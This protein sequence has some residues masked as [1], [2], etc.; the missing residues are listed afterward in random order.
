MSDY[1]PN[2]DVSPIYDLGN[3]WIDFSDQLWEQVSGMDSAMHGMRWT[4]D[5][6]MVV[7][8]TWTDLNNLELQPAI[9]SAVAIGNHINAYGDYIVQLMAQEEA[10]SNAQGLAGL[11]SSILSLPLM[12]FPGLGGAI[13]EAL[14]AALSK[15]LPDIFVDI[16]SSVGSTIGEALP[17]AVK[18]TGNVVVDVIGQAG[19][20]LGIDLGSQAI[21]DAVYHVPTDFSSPD[22]WKNEAT[23]LALAGGLPLLMH[24]PEVAGPV[25]TKLGDHTFGNTAEPTPNVGVHTEGGGPA[26]HG[27]AGVETVTPVLGGEPGGY[28]PNGGFTGRPD[29]TL[30]TEHPT[31][32]VD[33]PIDGVNRPVSMPPENVPERPAPVTDAPTS[34]ETV[35]GPG[36][37]GPPEGVTERPAPVIEPTAGGVNRP[38]GP[39]EGV[40]ERPAPV[41]EPVG[42]GSGPAEVVT[43]PSATS[44]GP[45][46]NGSPLAET[47]APP[48]RT[49]ADE[50]TGSG[51]HSPAVGE[52]GE[53]GLRGTTSDAPAT[54]TPVPAR[55]D[56]GPQPGT[57]AEG[58]R[59]A[60]A[61][62][63]ER[64]AVQPS[65]DGEA[66]AGT[67]PDA[68]PQTQTAVSGAGDAGTGRT[69][70][71]APDAPKAVEEPATSAAPGNDGVRP[72]GNEKLATSADA[73]PTRDGGAAAAEPAAGAGTG[74]GAGAGAGER[75]PLSSRSE[76]PVPVRPDAEA[77]PPT[78]Q[79][80][81]DL[82]KAP[83]EDPHTTTH[84]D[85]GARGTGSAGDA[86]RPGE[87]DGAPGER[88]ATAEPAHAQPAPDPTHA[89][90]T[91]E[92]TAP[93][94][95]APDEHFSEPDQQKA[96]HDKTTQLQS[97][98]HQKLALEEKYNAARDRFRQKFDRNVSHS[99]RLQKLDPTAREEVYAKAE[100]DL[101]AAFE[102][103]T[104][105]LGGE[106]TRPSDWRKADNAFR[107]SAKQLGGT[108]PGRG[109][110][111]L[112]K[113]G[114][115]AQS[116]KLVVKA[117]VGW[118][119]AGLSDGAIEQAASAYRSELDHAFH[120]TH[121]PL[122]SK[123]FHLVGAKTHLDLTL[124]NLAYGVRGLGDFHATAH[125]LLSDTK[126]LFD[127]TL[128]RWRTAHPEWKPQ[129]LDA[130]HNDQLKNL[131]DAFHQALNDELGKLRDA[132]HSDP[133]AEAKAQL[134]ALSAVR[135][136]WGDIENE[137]MKG[138]HGKLDSTQQLH[139]FEPQTAHDLHNAQLDSIRGGELPSAQTHGAAAAA[140]AK[141]AGALLDKLSGEPQ[142]LGAGPSLP[143]RLKQHL[144]D[145][146]STLPDRYRFED[147]AGPKTGSTL[148]SASNWRAPDGSRP[149]PE[150]LDLV[151]HQVAVKLHTVLTDLRAELN[152]A[153]YGKGAVDGAL[154]K[155]DS[156]L[157]G[158]ESSLPSLFSAA[159]HLPKVSE[160]SHAAWR[161]MTDEHPGLSKQ[162]PVGDLEAKFHQDWAAAYDQVATGGKLDAGGWAA[163]R[164][165]GPQPTPDAATQHLIDVGRQNLMSHTENVISLAE[166]RNWD[167]ETLPDKVDAA[168][169]KWEGDGGSSLVHDELGPDDVASVLSEVDSALKQDFHSLLD[170]RDLHGLS[171]DEAGAL[172]Q[173]WADK[174]AHRL[175]ELPA[176]FDRKVELSELKDSS[177]TQVD[178]HPSARGADPE[179]VKVVKDRYTTDQLTK[180][181]DRPLGEPADP[182]A[183]PAASLPGRFDYAA[184]VQQHADHVLDH[185]KSLRDNRPGPDAR[186]GGAL[187][188]HAVDGY[189]ADVLKKLGDAHQSGSGFHDYLSEEQPKAELALDAATAD[190]QAHFS[191]TFDVLPKANAALDHEGANHGYSDEVV[192]KAKESLNSD[193]RSAIRDHLAD[194]SYQLTPTPENLRGPGRPGDLLKPDALEDR[195]RFHQEL[196]DS[197]HSMT[198]TLYR[199]HGLT[200]DDEGLGRVGDE[201]AAKITALA[202]QHL[203]DLRT[204]ERPLVN[205]KL[206][207]RYQA[208]RK[209]VSDLLKGADRRVAHESDLE[210]ALW[211]A[212]KAF[213]K[214]FGGPATYG[215]DAGDPAGSGFAQEIA[216]FKH[217]WIELHDK[218]AGD[219]SLNVD[220]WLGSEQTSVDAF[221]KAAGA[222]GRP[223]PRDPGAPS[224]VP[225][226]SPSHPEHLTQPAPEPTP[227]SPVESPV[228]PVQPA[229]PE[230]LTSELPP[231]EHL[232]TAEQAGTAAQVRADLAHEKIT[233]EQHL[234]TV[235]PDFADDFHQLLD[236]PR[237]NGKLT[238]SQLDSIRSTFESDAERAFART[239]NSPVSQRDPQAV[240][241]RW[242]TEYLQLKNLAQGR[243]EYTIAHDAAIAQAVA[244]AEAAIDSPAHEQLPAPVRDAAK[245]SF[246][247]G[248]AAGFAHLHAAP[249]AYEVSKMNVNWPYLYQD[250]VKNIDTHI[251][252]QS[253]LHSHAQAVDQRFHQVLADH[254]LTPQ[255][256]HSDPWLTAQHHEFRAAALQSNP[257][258]R[259]LTLDDLAT[260]LGH[261][262]TLAHTVADALPQL[263]DAL[264]TAIDH[265]QATHGPDQQLSQPQIDD[266]STELASE[267]RKLADRQPLR[268]DGVG[269][270]GGVG[271]QRTPLLAPEQVGATITE[272]TDSLPG[273]ILFSA[274]LAH[275]AS[276]AIAAGLNTELPQLTGLLGQL[277]AANYAPEAVESALT[278]VERHLADLLSA[279]PEELAAEAGRQQA[280]VDAQQELDDLLSEH[281]E[282][283]AA[284]AARVRDWYG[285]SAMADH[286]R[287]FGRGD[288][289]V[290]D[291][292][293]RQPDDLSEL[294]DT[295]GQSAE[296]P[297][298]LPAFPSGTVELGAIISSVLDTVPSSSAI[299][300]LFD[301]ELSFTG[302]DA[303]KPEFVHLAPVGPGRTQF[304]GDDIRSFAQT[305]WD[306]DRPLYT[307]VVHGNGVAVTVSTTG[308]DGAQQTSELAGPEFG[309]VLARRPSLGALGGDAQI[310][311]AAC[312]AGATVDER[313]AIG[314]SVADRSGHVVWAATTD[315]LVTDNLAQAG[316]GLLPDEQG[317]PGAW[318]M[319]L[320]TPG[321][322]TARPE[323][324]TASTDTEPQT[325]A[326]ALPPVTSASTGTSAAAGA[327]AGAAEVSFSGAVM[328]APT[329]KRVADIASR[330][331]NTFAQ[332]LDIRGTGYQALTVAGDGDCFFT[333]L[334]TGAHHQLGDWGHQDLD[335]PGLRDTASAWFTG[336]QGAAYRAGIDRTGRSNLDI[337][338]GDVRTDELWQIT[339]RTG[340]APSDRDQ[341]LLRQQLSDEV[342]TAL[343]D[344]ATLASG[345]AAAISAAS[346]RSRQTWNR[347]LLVR[348]VYTLPLQLTP[349]SPATQLLNPAL[350]SAMPQSAMVDVAIRNSA[351]WTTQFFDEV[352]Q[353]TAR[354]VGLN[355]VVLD[356]RTNQLV[357]YDPQ[358]GLP[359]VHLYRTDAG[360]IGGAHYSALQPTGP[361]PIVATQPA[362]VQPTITQLAVVSTTATTTATKAPEKAPTKAPEKAKSSPEVLVPQGP[363]ELMD[364]AVVSDPVAVRNQLA[365][366]GSGALAPTDPLYH[367]LSDPAGVLADF[368]HD[369]QPQQLLALRPLLI[370]HL[371][372]W[373]EHHDPTPLAGLRPDALAIAGPAPTAAELADAV[374][375]WATL[376]TPDERAF[377]AEVLG[378]GLGLTLEVYGGS[379]K[380]ALLGTAGPANGRPVKAFLRDDPNGHPTLHL[381]GIPGLYAPPTRLTVDGQLS[382]SDRVL[383]IVGPQDF[384]VV[385][386][387]NSLT[388]VLTPDQLADARAQLETELSLAALQPLLSGMTRGDNLKL[389]LDVGG[390]QGDIEIS[391]TV[392]TATTVDTFKKLEFEDGSDSFDATGAFREG[393]S[394]FGGG[395]ILKGKPASETT[396]TGQLG[397]QRDKITGRVVASSGRMF[398]RAKTPEPALRVNAGIRLDFDFSEVRR[399]GL[400]LP[401]GAQVAATG[402]P[403]AQL[404]VVLPVQVA[405][406]AAEAD[407]APRPKG[408][409][410][411]LPPLRIEQTLGLGGSDVV[412]DVYTVDANGRRTKGGVRSLLGNAHQSSSLE[413]FGARTF[414]ADWRDVKDEFLGKVS[415]LSLHTSLKGMM[416]GEPMEVA[417]SESRG[418][419]L[420]SAQVATLAHL[421]N[422]DSSE[423]NTGTDVTRT[424]TSSDTYSW[425]GQT[426]FS[427][428]QTGIDEAPLRLNGSATAQY[429]RDRQS[430]D[431]FS[432][433][434]GNAVKMKVPG[435]IFNGVARLTFS[436]RKDPATA[437]DPALATTATS[438]PT[439]PAPAVA[440]A[441]LGFQVL[442]E[443]A[444][445]RPVSAPQTFDA[446]TRTPAPLQIEPPVVA[447]QSTAWRPKAEIW[448]L[449]PLGL[450]GLPESAVVYDVF[451]GP[452]PVPAQQPTASLNA[453]LNNLGGE[454]FGTNDWSEQRPAVRYSFSRDRVA[455]LLP[456]M[457]RN[458]PAQ[459]PLLTRPRK[460]DAQVSATAQLSSFAFLRVIDKAE[461]NVLNEAVE[462]TA[463]RMISWRTVGGQGQVGYQDTI[464]EVT[465]LGIPMI[466]GGYANRHREG[467]RSG[468]GSSTVSSAKFPEPM[469]AYLAT[470]RVDVQVSEAGSA[471]GAVT[472][473]TDVRFVVALP[474]SSA[475]QYVVADG[476][477]GQQIFTR[478]GAEAAA[479]LAA[480]TPVVATAP[481]PLAYQPPERVSAHGQIGAS[482]AVTKLHDDRAVLD[483]LH[484]ALGPSFADHWGRVEHDLLPYFDSVALRPLVPALTADKR[485]GTTVSA[486]GVTAEITIV[487]ATATMTEYLKSIK[488]FEFEVGSESSA[489]SGDMTDDLGTVTGTVG[490][491][492]KAPHISATASHSRNTDNL[493]SSTLDSAANAVSK[494]KTVEPAALFKGR[495]AFTVEVKLSNPLGIPTGT[496]TLTADSGGEFAFPI[497]DLPIDPATQQKPVPTQYYSPPPGIV[498]SLVLNA[499]TVVLNVT[500]AAQTPAPQAPAVQQPPVPQPVGSIP[501]VPLAPPAS[502][503]SPGTTGTSASATVPLLR[504]PGDQYATTAVLDQLDATGT[505][506][507]GSP[508]AWNATKSKLAKKF[509]AGRLQP[510]L[511]SLM[512]GQPWVIA[513]K[514]GSVTVTASVQEM[515]HTGN[516]K[517]SEFNSGATS[518]VTSGGSDGL[519][520]AA[521]G[522]S[523]TTAVQVVGASDPLGVLPAAVVAGGT[524]T[525]TSGQDQTAESVSAG[526]IGIGTK[527]KVPGSVFDGVALL[528]FEFRR[529]W[530]PWGRTVDQRV[531]VET[532]AQQHKLDWLQAKIQELTGQVGAEAEI[533]V[534]RRRYDAALAA[535]FN[536]IRTNAQAKANTA[537]AT[538]TMPAMTKTSFGVREHAFG[539]AKVGFQALVESADAVKVANA[540]DAHFTA[541]T[542]VTATDRA[543]QAVHGAEQVTLQ[544]PPAKV[545]DEGLA[546]NHAIR[547][548]PDVGSL[549]SL[550]DAE[551]RRNYPGVW[552]STL[553][554]GHKRANLVMDSFNREKLWANLPQLTAGHELKSATFRVN[555]R[556]AWVSVTAE[557]VDLAFHREEPGAEVALVGETT[558]RTTERKLNSR[559]GQ[560]MAQ[561]G[562]EF[563]KLPGKFNAIFTF[564]GGYRRRKGGEQ[565]TGGRVT[566]NSKIPIPL[567][568][569]DGHVKFRFTFHHGTGAKAQAA[570][571]Q[572]SGVVPFAV[573]IPK[574]EVKQQVTA[575]RATFFSKDEPL[576]TQWPP[577]AVQVTA[578]AAAA[579]LPAPAVFT[580]E[581]IEIEE[582]EAV[583]PILTFTVETID[584]DAPETTSAPATPVVVTALTVNTA[585][586]Y[587]VETIEIE[588]SPAPSPTVTTPGFT[589]ETID[590]EDHTTPTVT[591]SGAVMSSSVG[592]DTASEVSDDSDALSVLDPF[593]APAPAPALAVEPVPV[594]ELDP[595]EQLAQVQHY[596][597]SLDTLTLAVSAGPGMGHQS[598]AVAVLKSLRDLGYRGEV[599]VAYP[600]STASRIDQLLPGPTEAPDRSAPQ[601]ALGPWRKQPLDEEFN[602]YSETAAQPPSGLPRS[603]L[604]ITGAFDGLSPQY[605]DGYT[606]AQ[607]VLDQRSK[608]LDHFNTDALLVLQPYAWPARREFILRPGPGQQPT[609]VVLTPGQGA[610]LGL[611]EPPIEDALLSPGAMFRA[612][613]NT[614]FDL[615]G[616]HNSPAAQGLTALRDHLDAQA[617]DLMPVYGLHQAEATPV[618]TLLGY[619][620]HGLHATLPT[621]APPTVIAV[622]GA[623]DKPWADAVNTA[624]P[625]S[626]G[627]RW[628]QTTKL[629]D[630]DLTT[631]LTALLPGDVLLLDVGNLPRPAFH[632]LFAQGTLPALVM[633]N[634]TANLLRVLD[635]PFL[636]LL[637]DRPLHPATGSEHDDAARQLLHDTATALTAGPTWAALADRIE[638]YDA[639]LGTL[640]DQAARAGARSKLPPEVAYRTL[641]FV[642]QSAVDGLRD[643][644]E[645]AQQQSDS[646][647]LTDL[648]TWP[649]A[650][651][652]SP[653]VLDA[654]IAALA[655]E[656]DRLSQ[657]I[658]AQ[659]DNGLLPLDPTHL[660]TVT[661]S[662]RRLRDPQSA[663]SQ[664]FIELAEQ[665]RNPKNDQVRQGLVAVVNQLHSDGGGFR[666]DSTP[667]QPST[668]NDSYGYDDYSTS[669]YAT[670][671]YADYSNYANYGS[672]SEEELAAAPP[673]RTGAGYLPPARLEDDP[674][675][676]S[677]QYTEPAQQ[678]QLPEPQAV[679]VP[680]LPTLD[681]I[682]GRLEAVSWDQ[683]DPSHD[684]RARGL[685]RYQVGGLRLEALPADSPLR[686]LADGRGGDEPPRILHIHAMMPD[687]SQG[688]Q[689]QITDALM[690]RAVRVAVN[691]DAEDVLV[692]TGGSAEQADLLH[693]LGLQPLDATGALWHTTTPAL[694]A[695]L[696]ERP[697]ATDLKVTNCETS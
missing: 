403:D 248:V 546:A 495:V 667:A 298:V 400:A 585:P 259:S 85:A 604:A 557:V 87:H 197:L 678:E 331:R 607:S 139:D 512:A 327:G 192:T 501:L 649:P 165:S 45:Q 170:G 601:D 358:V 320:P 490:L 518:G 333:S 486:G 247:A 182:A 547:D 443:A 553:A 614:D 627:R 11:I 147:S 332:G 181:A 72:T 314:Q 485:W 383:P 232:D 415:L 135:K 398:T 174:V 313:L 373:V 10:Q 418:T 623:G 238:N 22:F 458:V 675:A 659:S 203:G 288:L 372:D 643:D 217:D 340:R 142:S 103:H 337:L 154:G 84:A 318:V 219:G 113:E 662:F 584:L 463:S 509:T 528:H 93:E 588:E 183:D 530:R 511:K 195:L 620:A 273:R 615:S 235:R 550:I 124:E 579:T 152:G 573:S 74:A 186:T 552:D 685:L 616:L 361:T 357:D 653:A 155:L 423:F 291:W 697:E 323:P 17:S 172:H 596:L 496:Q 108:F 213:D 36:A 353:V 370:A 595:A 424:I 428:Q 7:E 30:V 683:S 433:R 561:L 324:M 289:D 284:G 150:A 299:G 411:Y 508:Q 83:G 241:H 160:E 460:P 218:L 53:P 236:S 420:V 60:P 382:S 523:Q 603:A 362:A 507:F 500:P 347:L 185:L 109:E 110:L 644:L 266:L 128:D 15:I 380:D 648:P 625:S 548:L 534:L 222:P 527:S 426:P 104:D 61:S 133:A 302:L 13:G 696:R 82:A 34:S 392:A 375:D 177:N 572:A 66:P 38:V 385:Q 81:N 233:Q 214:A 276:A 641:G 153:G 691:E 50:G 448:G 477:E 335:Q 405:T 312:R 264:N 455:A 558:G 188:A 587:S 690:Q 14:G 215:I 661:E 303:R 498:N 590:L 169:Q 583:L 121:G 521:K 78:G 199:D 287:I 605:D 665:G 670:D 282:L 436:L 374:R 642:G 56:N 502:Q 693:P 569:F 566:A 99:K 564:G 582:P 101:R 384:V 342:A 62:P 16:I 325:S 450:A 348:P 541:G 295:T 462:G 660:D 97:D 33:V 422:T 427:A 681:L 256:L 227:E 520:A 91:H 202:D 363:F 650:T 494:S 543:V 551:G 689:Q 209:D 70:Q 478:A 608:V 674:R 118:K 119:D 555:G 391:A 416:A 407:H 28:V 112:A 111:H 138:L 351:L 210:G 21:G 134:K 80:S 386:L 404:H 503:A 576:G 310:I 322:A 355:L 613:E 130:L 141:D 73:A 162:G 687:D 532:P 513:L 334:L 441:E 516:T 46:S 115:P 187:P 531:P 556:P 666:Y 395:L 510:R 396:L 179:T 29:S 229:T 440:T 114:W 79:S 20:Q 164:H 194:H 317:R 484:T 452:L 254:Q 106:G 655:G 137:L 140:A 274:G 639:L 92:H 338:L 173:E 514:H 25:I 275:L 198:D 692:S 171:S 204:G 308:E 694:S 228:E 257:K 251:S 277:R 89:E 43:D 429:G 57:P 394:R 44:S 399:F 48:V 159:E 67:A 364:I 413:A 90:P 157:K 506:V 567:V 268:S 525:H 470:A 315:V 368:R 292:I 651:A 533:A 18:F 47:S 249:S 570:A 95:T 75:V 629:T 630:P 307:A 560:F 578:P 207:P 330:P 319:F 379:A 230:H 86:G 262:L 132:P 55:L 4:G 272:L 592:S 201:Y 464:D 606:T 439:G 633:A 571:P 32:G 669:N 365:A 156:E 515:T 647:A 243:A 144:D 293:S 388:G 9:A 344:S 562:A 680:L 563:S 599:V 438:V 191:L 221:A 446:T 679:P 94:H 401:V 602:P 522:A 42:T 200:T 59:P 610:F 105:G 224:S 311:L 671:S 449:D 260:D 430:I 369:P 65:G 360:G 654:W 461:L 657:L 163:G 568:H 267:A 456:A 672:D 472:G 8:N 349:G 621:E 328:M 297:V 497:R 356:G 271:Q 107:K 393:R 686:T 421:R 489:T 632:W 2:F 682:N 290:L 37:G 381:A 634:G 480:P 71:P 622:I 168:F 406:P 51:A 279:V 637:T 586:T 519:T 437:G 612:H 278:T 408:M 656:S 410:D 190:L 695:R 281:P 593:E 296:L 664:Y 559:H 98:Y 646:G 158:V 619:A 624:A 419:I 345:D 350:L 220:K 270:G 253:D 663:V 473:H 540:A 359:S 483:A 136:S 285:R 35:T 346:A 626:D 366:S 676:L 258:W 597:N 432:V 377:F 673:V 329:V 240:Q 524:V 618:R 417:L 542:P 554:G 19:I 445:A 598:S 234:D 387:L 31:T 617:V 544:V 225:S 668:E 451:A 127:K 146:S 537:A 52:P 64:P 255:D 76:E 491:A 475:E 184:K 237:Y 180:A 574:E 176:R 499:A 223:G 166:R 402:R 122:E 100:Q 125:D 465:S 178:Q 193:L 609:T 635:R 39:P 658:A 397:V 371:A 529:S 305:P 24:A 294:P 283:S 246:L 54:G 205:D 469:V 476:D 300:R 216:D 321:R 126:G 354:A 123:P 487:S 442:T 378:N 49:P 580:V 88:P 545:W 102:E 26:V 467:A 536:R 309:E 40:T 77:K 41:N 459:S 211:D 565:T 239:F 594:L 367:W 151:S 149:S 425:S 23:N 143:D 326:S 389:P 412:K 684:G 245:R 339:G 468:E 466:G 352:P 252:A 244:D 539:Y 265:W 196:D 457:S 145:L 577:V 677:H 261:R 226:P 688:R 1:Q 549:R 148:D 376:S 161:S 175:D 5:G 628:L 645:A 390:W 479:L 504:A 631:T 535:Q 206:D 131:D 116:D 591:F 301:P 286:H 269:G 454:F 640:A 481:A 505:Q 414:G 482:D 581:T 431:Q 343:H 69:A 316:F 611:G 493:T 63:N 12:L 189:R 636:P 435:A 280:W 304:S 231:A 212:G 242:N 68:K 250:L 575:P 453:L 474:K 6:H 444:E 3:A 167:L 129:E 492:L 589:I 434:A 488:D 652:P 471:T 517:A 336:P 409:Q 447:A 341:P 538:G 27:P 638:S 120:A 526:R 263:D 306:T 96:W 600:P 208:F 117:K 58:A